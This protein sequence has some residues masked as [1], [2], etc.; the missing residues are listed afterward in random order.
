MPNTTLQHEKVFCENCG[1]EPIAIS[2][3]YCPNCSEK[4][5]V[6]PLNELLEWTNTPPGF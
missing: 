6:P 5:F 2:K 1:K 4:D 3:K